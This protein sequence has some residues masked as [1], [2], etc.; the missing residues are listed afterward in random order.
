MYWR[1]AGKFKTQTTEVVDP[2]HRCKDVIPL[3]PLTVFRY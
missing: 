1:N 3:I 2:R